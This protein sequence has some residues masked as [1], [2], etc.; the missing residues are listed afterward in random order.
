M[1]T[2][3]TNWLRVEQGG[4]EEL[5]IAFYHARQLQSLPLHHT[6]PFDRMLIAQ[7]QTEKLTLVTHDRGVEPYDVPAFWI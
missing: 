2:N 3:L 5:P 1:L 6:D 4:F 7:T